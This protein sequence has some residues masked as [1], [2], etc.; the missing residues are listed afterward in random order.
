MDDNVKGKNSICYT[1]LSVYELYYGFPYK[2]LR[3]MIDF[4][5]KLPKE[6]FRFID[7]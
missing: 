7:Q 6:G 3:I 5:S 1:S 4:G 2:S